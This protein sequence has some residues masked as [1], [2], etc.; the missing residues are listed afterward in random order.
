MT[1]STEQ[2][3]SHFPALER[4]V[5]DT[6]V[7]YF[8]GPGG[9]QVARPV[10]TA[11]EEY[12]FH[13]NANTHWAYPTSE[14]TDDALAN[15]RRACAALLNG[16][17]ED[18]VFGA[19]MTTLTYHVSRAVGRSL[20]S[21]D[22]IVVTE[23]DHH[24]NID[25]WRA[26]E[27][28]RGVVVRI[29]RMIPETGQLDLDH[30]RNLV[31]PRTRLVAIGAASNAL[32]TVNDVRAAVEAARDVG[33]LSFVDGVH[34]APHTLPDVEATGCDFFACS[35]YKFYGPHVG[36]LYVRADV[37]EVVD[38]PR[39]APAPSRPPE[40]PETG[41]LNHEGIVGT[42]AVVEWL[43]SLSPGGSLRESL[44]STYAGLHDRGEQLIA[45]MWNGLSNLPGIRLFGPEPG[46]PRTPTLAF[47][48]D[49]LPSEEVTRRLASE[50]VF[51]TH[52]DFYAQ[53]VVRR[54]GYERDG[55]VRAGC[56]CYT[57]EEEV[58][59]LVEGV[60]RIVSR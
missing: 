21:G 25:P 56:A 47:A 46:K 33:A 30:L 1:A 7:A 15:A 26:L 36:V 58:D 6:P 38:F 43:G 40:R 52:G 54:L 4:R 20:S 22:E 48:V 29:V 10:V 23:L 16:R 50:A 60:S 28:E 44:E 57:S 18:I 42:A 2:I 27:V 13:H 3:R 39:L 51:V 34:Y 45:R 5:G 59:R 41:T 12:L 11:M 17:P 9:T 53:T 8:D 35:A 32:G 37:S 19:N 14:E 49:G 55:L 24:A 31:G